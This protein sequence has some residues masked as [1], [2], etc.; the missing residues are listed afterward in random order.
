MLCLIVG[1]VRPSLLLLLTINMRFSHRQ[2]EAM[3]V[4]ICVRTLERFKIHDLRQFALKTNQNLTAERWFGEGGYGTGAPP[5]KS[6]LSEKTPE[7][8]SR[9][10]SGDP[11]IFRRFHQRRKKLGSNIMLSGGLRN[12]P[13]HFRMI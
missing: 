5:R 8:V 12:P 1:R 2:N 4:K 10:L 7:L 11:E 9:F 6:D 3:K 13:L